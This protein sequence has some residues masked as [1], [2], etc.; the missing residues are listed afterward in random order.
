MHVFDRDD[1]LI[2]SHRG[3]ARGIAH[4]EPALSFCPKNDH[5][6]TSFIASFK[7][8]PSY[9]LIRLV[10]AVTLQNRGDMSLPSDSASNRTLA[11]GTFGDRGPQNFLSATNFVVPQKFVSNIMKTK[12]SPF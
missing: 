3:V 7:F 8:P 10:F 5:F 12:I 4:G 1:L 6:K 2:R 11:T 9:E